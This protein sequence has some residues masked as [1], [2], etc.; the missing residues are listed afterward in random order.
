MEVKLKIWII[1]ILFLFQI[2]IIAQSDTVSKNKQWL[3]SSISPVLLMSGSIYTMNKNVPLNNF[4]IQEKVQNK[5]PNFHSKL[6]DYL[7]VAPAATPY[8]LDWTKPGYTKN[9]FW[10]RSLI[11]AKSQAIMMAIVFPTKYLTKIERPDGRANNSFP[12][13]HTAQAFV[14]ATFMHEELKHKSIWYSI[15]AYSVATT[16]GAYRVLNN[17][18]WIS[19][20]F[21]GAAIGI[22]STKIAYLTHRYK[23]AK[24]RSQISFRFT[25]IFYASTPTF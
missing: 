18:H 1:S 10:N 22:L 11:L 24:K 19:D 8:L 12:S 23:W 14:T 7:W 5:Y 4:D 13:G 21:A 9:D 20:V 17:R 2:S 16:V 3:K 25:P 6:D 15:G